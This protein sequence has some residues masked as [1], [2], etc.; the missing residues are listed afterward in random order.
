MAV[1]QPATPAAPEIENWLR[2]AR[3]F[4]PDP[5]FTAQANAT[6]DLYLEAETDFEAFW[7]RLARERISWFK[8]F[9][10]TLEWDLPFAK[11][12]VGGE[13]NMAYNCVDGHV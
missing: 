8:P 1:E 10:K 9:E 2:E 11:W 13:L 5:D 4:P 7:E 3:T 6:A 12:F